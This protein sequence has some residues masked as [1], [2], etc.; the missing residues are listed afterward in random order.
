MK[1]VKDGNQADVEVQLVE[2]LAEDLQCACCSELVYK[3][4]LVVPCQHFFC[5]R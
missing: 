4:V 5:G 2:V 1:K 3:P